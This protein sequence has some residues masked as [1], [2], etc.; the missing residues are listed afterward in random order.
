M[1]EVL[2]QYPD[3]FRQGIAIELAIFEALHRARL[4]EAQQWLACARGG[5]VDRSRRHLAE[6]AVA[7]L[8]DDHQVA[9][10]A[11]DAA[12]SSRHQAMDAGFAHLSVDQIADM[13]AS[14]L[15]QSPASHAAG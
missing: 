8:Q 3:G 11:L 7:L 6:A 12:E 14:L 1:G 15:P 9:A 5:I 4:S 13:R 2:D 10:S